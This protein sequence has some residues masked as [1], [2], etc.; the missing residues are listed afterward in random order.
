MGSLVELEPA[1]LAGV[2]TERLEAEICALAGHLAAGT[3][4]WVLM[5]AEYD[6]RQGWAGWGCQS[7]ANWLSWKCGVGMH[8]SRE[9]LRVGHAL[10]TLPVIRTAFERGELSY[11][12]VRAITRVAGARNEAA[13]VDIARASTAHQLDRLVAATAKAERV[14]DQGFA[15]QLAD[16]SYRA[17]FDHDR[18]LYTAKV[19][20]SPETADC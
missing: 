14:W 18:A 7:A 16:R 12:Q 17:G 19:T 2:V 4:R 8:A 10:A 13:L 5:I 9:K 6:N 1:V 11:S 3:A 20:L 15:A